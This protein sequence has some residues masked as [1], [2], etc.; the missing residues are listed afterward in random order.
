MFNSSQEFQGYLDS[1]DTYEMSTLNQTIALSVQNGLDYDDEK[2]NKNFRVE[3]YSYVKNE[4]YP[5]GHW[6]PLQAVLCREFF[7]AQIQEEQKANKPDG[8][9]SYWFDNEQ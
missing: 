6:T 8:F 7:A 1:D 3:F 2:V 9:Y 5:V 4:T